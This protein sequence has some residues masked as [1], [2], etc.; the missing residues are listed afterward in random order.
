MAARGEVGLDDPVQRYL[1]DSVRVPGSDSQPITLRL[2]S[3]QRSGLP[4]MPTNFAPREGEH[5]TGQATGQSAF[6]MWASAPDEFFLKVADAQVTF[7]RGADGKVN[8]LVL[9]QNGRDMRA[10]RATAQP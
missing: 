5:L 7:T 10:E 1:P 4:R 3:A 6:R 9:H 2:L 8:G